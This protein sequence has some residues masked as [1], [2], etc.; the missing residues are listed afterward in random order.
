MSAISTIAILS[1]M[2]KYW[3]GIL[4]ASIL[5]SAYFTFIYYSE[6]GD[7]P[8]HSFGWH[9]VVI[10]IV[11]A[12]FIALVV[13]RLNAFL[14]GLFDWKKSFSLRLLSG[15]ILGT[16]TAL[17]I[18]YGFAWITIKLNS[19][20]SFDEITTNYSEAAIKLAIIALITV[21]IYSIIYLAL[22]S[23]NQY[24]VVQIET[25]KHERKQLKLQFD[26]LKSQL[27][28]HYLFNCLNTISSL[29]YKDPDAAETFI[30]RLALTYQYI[31]TTN[32]EKLV[33]LAEEVEFVKSYYYLLKVRYEN[34]FDLNIDLPQE[35]LTSKVPPLTL[36]I[37]VEN[38][39]KHNV[40]SKEE[41]LEVDIV[42][43][44]QK[45]LKVSNTKT[46]RPSSVS[47]FKV[48]LEN[49]RKRYK[50]F[51]NSTISIEDAEKFTVRLPIIDEGDI[52]EQTI[53]QVA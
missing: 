50:F 18:A 48:G 4:V 36:Q 22:F 37:L 7:H 11:A 45:F 1:S 34:S 12:N 5:G 27:S 51:T 35:I 23:Y 47:S 14:N 29:V 26:A 2:R 39:V 33:S 44:E 41:P 49:I 9:Y 20:A 46:A 3:I 24:A 19:A 43:E 17:A 52:D 31:L 10:S 15:I 42:S 38:A 25:V 32:K 13:H 53:N 16:A 8:F 21:M 40:F 28:P 6:Y 30:R